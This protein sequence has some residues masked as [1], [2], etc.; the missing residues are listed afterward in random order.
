M[1]VLESVRTWFAT[2]AAETVANYR[3]LVCAIRQGREVEPE[4]VAAVL[5]AAGKTL[6]NA[7]ADAEKLEQR[8]AWAAELAAAVDAQAERPLIER[9]LTEA[10]ATFDEAVRK[11]TEEYETLKASLRWRDIEC[12]RVIGAAIQSEIKLGQSCPVEAREAVKR[13][14]DRKFLP[15]AQERGEIVAQIEDTKKRLKAA[16]YEAGIEE[17]KGSAYRDKAK[18]GAAEVAKLKGELARL[19]AALV[20]LDRRLAEL[21]PE[22]KRLRDEQLRPWPSTASSLT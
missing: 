16:E 1:P 3:E 11:A 4:V 19:E 9:R 18:R 20:P 10:K 21:E 8:E 13:F 15:V 17:R 22:G 12:Q 14:H 7:E 5:A 2:R 6:A